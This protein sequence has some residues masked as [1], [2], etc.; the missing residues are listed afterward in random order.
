MPTQRS[1]PKYSQQLCLAAVGTLLLAGCLNEENRQQLVDAPRDQW[2]FTALEASVAVESTTAQIG[3]VAVSIPTRG[4]ACDIS[5]EVKVVNQ[6]AYRLGLFATASYL[7]NG[8]ELIANAEVLSSVIEARD[9]LRSLSAGASVP[10]LHVNRTWDVNATNGAAVTHTVTLN[11]RYL[12]NETF[13]RFLGHAPVTRPVLHT[14]VVADGPDGLQKMSIQ[15]SGRNCGVSGVLQA[16]P[17]RIVARARDFE[18]S[19]AA[20]AIPWLAQAA[21]WHGGV[22]GDD[23]VVW[24]AKAPEGVRSEPMTVLADG[25]ATTFEVP[26]GTI[27]FPLQESGWTVTVPTSFAPSQGNLVVFFAASFSGPQIALPPG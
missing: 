13:F 7:Q 26:D 14:V 11:A 19:S 1:I 3:I 10:G 21:T 25:S 22:D 2:N 17:D 5:F 18:G 8:S 6:D 9:G 15:A 24:I 16:L 12:A 27:R 20:A 4:G 23:R